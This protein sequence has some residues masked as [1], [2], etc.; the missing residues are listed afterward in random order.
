MTRQQHKYS[1]RI[2]LHTYE[3]T[4]DLNIKYNQVQVGKVKSLLTIFW[5]L[6]FL[7]I[8]IIIVTYRISPIIF[9]YPKSQ[10][11]FECTR[12]RYLSCSLFLLCTVYVYI[13]VLLC[14]LCCTRIS[15]T[16]VN[17]FC[18]KNGGKCGVMKRSK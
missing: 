15:Y 3:L 10:F 9:L 16:I 17:I 13:Y 4:Y 11:H 14:A 18:G 8:L 12:T 1:E 7:F 2:Q 6:C 5:S